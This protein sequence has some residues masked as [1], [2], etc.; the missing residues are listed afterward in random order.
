MAINISKAMA[1]S[2]ISLFVLSKGIYLINE[3]VMKN[4][5]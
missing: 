3:N 2:E 5:L 1:K 4:V